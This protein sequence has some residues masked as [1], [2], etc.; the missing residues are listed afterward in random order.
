VHEDESG[1]ITNLK[2]HLAELVE[3]TIAAHDGRVV[4][5]TGDGILMEFPSAVA[6]VSCAIEIQRGMMLRN[7][8]TSED[9]RIEFRIGINLSD[10]VVDDADILGD[11]VNIAARI[12]SIAEANGICVSDDVCRIVRSKIDVEL[13]SVG[14]IVFK[15]LPK[16]IKVYRV[17]LGAQ[18]AARASVENAHSS[19]LVS[20]E[21]L[22]AVMPFDNLSGDPE[23]IYFSDGITND[24]I[25]NLSRFPEIGVIASHS[26]FAFKGRQAGIG[27]IAQELGVRYIVEGSVQRA[28]DKLRI[29][30]QLIDASVDRHLWSDRFQG[31]LSAVFDMQEEITRKVAVSVVSRVQMAERG[32][33]ER[34]PP[35]S[36]EAYDY[37]LRGY[38][39]WYLWTPQANRE[40][41]DYFTNARD[42]DPNFAR[43]HS[44]YS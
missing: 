27:S 34:K 36:L 10:V 26:V 13:E 20:A 9:R 42:A 38:R 15:S 2:R 39:V 31:N 25:S 17:S 1:T 24:L 21:P 22:L 41:R 32:R 8:K 29:N 11:G 40:A 5:T 6:A 23:Q 37:L 4:K 30:V 14:D 44:A 3:P 33:S 16:P 7:A 28:G 18:R 43:A 19:K 12:E 35:D